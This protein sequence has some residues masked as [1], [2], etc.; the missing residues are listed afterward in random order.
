MTDERR[1][2]D[3]PATA[4]NVLGRR[5]WAAFVVQPARVVVAHVH[6]I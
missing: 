4:A 3:H 1:P 5:G 6:G 2:L